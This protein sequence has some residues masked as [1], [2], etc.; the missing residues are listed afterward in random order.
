M[1]S[2]LAHSPLPS[3]SALHTIH[4]L[5][6]D[7][8]DLGPAQMDLALET[9]Y[10]RLGA[11]VGA[12]SGMWFGA[13]RI[14]KNAQDIAHGWRSPAIQPWKLD[15][16]IAE[17]TRLFRESLEAKNEV[18]IGATTTQMMT[19]AGN[20]RAYRLRDG[21]IDFP[22]FRRTWHYEIYYK[23]ADITDRMWIGFPVNADTESIFT[24]DRVG[25]RRHFTASDLA[26]AAYALRGIK[27]FHRQLLLRHGVLAASSRLS[28]T[29]WRVVPLL[30]T[31]RTEKEIAATLGL[32]FDAAH[33][34]ARGIYQKFAVRGRAGLM[35]LWAG[36]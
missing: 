11:M 10:Q 20:H 12:D 21:W 35:A 31:D 3:A 27:W 33:K 19:D 28:P 34:H 25:S 36:A 24:F 2:K 15:P 22:A 17:L 30:L 14:S 8:T 9:L 32:T 29:E 5:W 7:L 16:K 18:C 23:K 6:D 4:S 26:T 13:V 1:I